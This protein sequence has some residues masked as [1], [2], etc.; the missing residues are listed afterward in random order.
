MRLSR[1][2]PALLPKGLTR[3]LGGAYPSLNSRAC[4]SEI[5]PD[6]FYPR[7]ARCAPRTSHRGDPPAH[8]PEPAA[9]TDA[10]E[11][12]RQI[13]EIVLDAFFEL[14]FQRTLTFARLPF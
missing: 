13:L 4:A 14:N 5:V 7:L 9:T 10:R 11:R 12:R 6:H 1:C 3:T 2:L 8:F